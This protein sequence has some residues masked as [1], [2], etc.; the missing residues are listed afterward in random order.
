M[1]E[2]ALVG[3]RGHILYNDFSKNK[4]N[5]N[6]SRLAFTAVTTFHQAT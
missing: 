1:C 5:K 6:I 3:Q 4:Q 2:I